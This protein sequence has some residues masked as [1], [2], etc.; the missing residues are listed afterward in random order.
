MSNFCGSNSF[1][2]SN[3]STIIFIVKSIEAVVYKCWPFGTSRGKKNMDL[4]KGKIQRLSQE[5]L[6]YP[7]LIR[8]CKNCWLYTCIYDIKVHRRRAFPSGE[9]NDLWRSNNFPLSEA[10]LSFQRRTPFSRTLS[11]YV[12]S[13]RTGLWGCMSDSALNPSVSL[14]WQYL[15]EKGEKEKKLEHLSVDVFSHIAVTILLNKKI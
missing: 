8:A 4:W 6:L 13:E 10:C 15:S 14:L 1:D 3:N 9:N 7:R 5:Y 12:Q 11:I 2:S